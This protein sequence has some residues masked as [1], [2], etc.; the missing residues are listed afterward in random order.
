MMTATHHSI[1]LDSSVCSKHL[2]LPTL[3]TAAT[4]ADNEQRALI[5][6]QPDSGLQLVAGP[7]LEEE[8][9]DENLSDPLGHSGAGHPEQLHVPS[10]E[11]QVVVPPLGARRPGARRPGEA[12]ASCFPH[13]LRR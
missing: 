1:V 2:S 10:S 12:A 9:S 11:L 3:S 7:I 13:A 5:S 6:V 8:G 4:A